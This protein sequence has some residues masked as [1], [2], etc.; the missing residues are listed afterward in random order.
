MIDLARYAVFPS[1]VGRM[2]IIDLEAE[3]LGMLPVRIDA[4]AGDGAGEADAARTV[5]H[6]PP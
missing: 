5:E 1:A 6:P 4:G 2:F 3:S